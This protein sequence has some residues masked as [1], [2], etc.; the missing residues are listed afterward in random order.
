MD[1]HPFNLN[2]LQIHER[3]LSSNSTWFNVTHSAERIPWSISRLIRLMH[4]AP[5]FMM[6]KVYKSFHCKAWLTFKPRE[7][8]HQPQGP[9]HISFAVVFNM[10]FYFSKVFWHGKGSQWPGWMEFHALS[11]PSNKTDSRWPCHLCSQ[12][13]EERMTTNRRRLS[14]TRWGMSKA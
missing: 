5:P 14:P 6:D 10:E 8:R 3:F 12:E 1:F 13:W 4:T 7:I 2:I 9:T 11:T